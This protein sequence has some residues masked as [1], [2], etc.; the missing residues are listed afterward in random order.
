MNEVGVG[1][2]GTFPRQGAVEK[3]TIFTRTSHIPS[4]SLKPM[5]MQMKFCHFFHI[6]ST[7]LG[8]FEQNR[9]QSTR[10]EQIRVKDT[11]NQ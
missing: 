11:R 3:K 7:Y 1:Q 8:I 5:E 2:L 10:I 4:L 6:D 9:L